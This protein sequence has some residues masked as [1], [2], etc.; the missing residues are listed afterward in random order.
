MTAIFGA[1]SKR[2]GEELRFAQ[3]RG[4]MRNRGSLSIS[5]RTG[6][7]SFKGRAEHK[8][9]C[10]IRSNLTVRLFLETHQ[11]FINIHVVRAL[12]VMGV[13]TLDTLLDPLVGF[14]AR[15]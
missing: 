10:V 13:P 7:N 5:F 1:R 11:G 15:R 2:D 3:F 4:T 12:N 9:S 14:T 6:R 8:I